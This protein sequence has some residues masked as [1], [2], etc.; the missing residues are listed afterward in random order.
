MSDMN[1]HLRSTVETDTT[2]FAL[3][4]LR[5]L[6][7]EKIARIEIIPADHDSV[8]VSLFLESHPGAYIQIDIPNAFSVGYM[9][10]GPRGLYEIMVAA[11]FNDGI[12][13]EI[14]TLSRYTHTTYLK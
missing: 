6:P 3:E 8:L 13:D 1:I 9:G 14:Y 4:F 10:E 2:Y 7:L 12:A 11:G 5:M